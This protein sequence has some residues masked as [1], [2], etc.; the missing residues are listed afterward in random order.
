MFASAIITA[1][2]ATIVSASS[3]SITP[4]DRYSS[5]VGVLGCYIN[6]N[7]VAYW[8]QSVDCDNICV[9][10]SYGGRSVYLL[11]I[12]QSGGAYDI[13][14]DAWN[15]LYTG[16]SATSHPVSGGGIQM[17]YE[18]VP[19]DNCRGLI[20]T[21]SGKLPLSAPNSMNYVAN[22]LTAKP[23]SWVARNHELR[24]ILKP[25]CTL[26]YDEVC[27]LN[28]A[29]S[30]Q[31]SCPHQLG[32]PAVLTGKPVVDILYPTGQQVVAP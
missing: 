32:V 6:T 23:N 29:V 30:N 28:L 26:G 16:Q 8:P 18:P 17:N 14:Y 2:L 10:V 21:P 4:H 1:Y 7:R 20:K 5:S 24:N 11:R 25:T 12:D 19:A 22:C 13:S 31:P 9:R 27:T 3:A 15:Y